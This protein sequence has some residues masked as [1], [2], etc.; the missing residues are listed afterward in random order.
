MCLPF[1][2]DYDKNIKIIIQQ[3]WYLPKYRNLRLFST[4]FEHAAILWGKIKK[5]KLPIK[6]RACEH[7]FFTASYATYFTWAKVTLLM[8]D[9]KPS[10][11]DNRFFNRVSVHVSKPH[12]Y[13]IILSNHTI[14]SSLF[15]FCG[16]ILFSYDYRLS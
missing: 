14:F 13:H 10:N 15:Y 4:C 16:K 3:Q 12:K 1:I 9:V 5:L 11:N 2:C 7:I 6:Y 8:S